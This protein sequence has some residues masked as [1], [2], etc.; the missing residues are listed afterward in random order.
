MAKKEPIYASRAQGLAAANDNGFGP[1][2]CSKRIFDEQ[3][4]RESRVTWMGD[5]DFGNFSIRP[6]SAANVYDSYVD[7]GRLFGMSETAISPNALVPGKVEKAQNGFLKARDRFR[8]KHQLS[9]KEMRHIHITLKVE[10]R[11]G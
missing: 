3:E 7:Y 8:R 6:A 5:W 11:K 9:T 2:T 4:I 1:S 10:R